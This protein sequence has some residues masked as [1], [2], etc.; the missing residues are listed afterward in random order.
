MSARIIPFTRSRPTSVKQLAAARLRETL[1]PPLL[2][3]HG[4]SP[5]PWARLIG[6]REQLVFW[7]AASD[8]HLPVKPKRVAYNG[9]HA[10]TVWRR[11]ALFQVVWHASF[12]PGENEFIDRLIQR[13]RNA[14]SEPALETTELAVEI[15]RW[16]KRM[17]DTAPGYRPGSLDQ[18]DRA[19]AAF[20]DAAG[21]LVT[22]PGAPSP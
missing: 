18:L 5:R 9:G 20:N 1:A 11:G 14:S 6:S 3:D 12:D 15:W 21:A 13:V 22:P 10:P 2:L 17:I 19:I 16:R 8:E 7:G 4:E